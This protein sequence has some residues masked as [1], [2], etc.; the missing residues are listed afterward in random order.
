MVISEWEARQLIVLH[1][2]PVF[3]YM[4]LCMQVTLQEC[5]HCKYI[6]CGRGIARMCST[7]EKQAYTMTGSPAERG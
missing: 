5:N 2:D 4:Y 1:G 6:S 3:V 7:N